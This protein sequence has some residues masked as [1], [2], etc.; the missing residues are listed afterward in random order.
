MLD[1]NYI[2]ENRELVENAITNKGEKD[3]SVV[4]KVLAVDEEWRSKVHE[5]DLLRSESN[6]KAK[7]I[8]KLMGQ[9]KKEEAQAII[10]ET[11]EMKERIKDLEEDVKKLR[12]DRDNLLL[13]I[14]NVPHPSVPVGAT[15]DDNETF[16][17]WGNPHEDEWRKPH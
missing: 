5:G 3:T 10:K 16:K 13:R 11:S 15:E 2:K 14:P 7:E 4:E 17:T 6:T 8:G 9:G 12:E 1:I